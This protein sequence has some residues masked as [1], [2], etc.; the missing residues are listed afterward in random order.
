MNNSTNK[1]N[2]SRIHSLKTQCTPNDKTQ[3]FCEKIFDDFEVNFKQ[4]YRPIIIKSKTK[5]IGRCL[6]PELIEL[7]NKSETKLKQ[8][9][10]F[11]TSRIN[12]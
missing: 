2:N 7:K 1:K 11:Q 3:D 4:K 9:V 5:P 8:K 10:K 12:T 6:Y